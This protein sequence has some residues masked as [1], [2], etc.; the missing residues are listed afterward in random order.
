MKTLSI[1]HNNGNSTKY[2]LIEDGNN[3]PIAY[4]IETSK[5]VIEVLENARKGRIRIKLALGD[6]KTGKDWGEVHDISGRIGLSKGSDARYP[7][8][9]YN[10]RSYGGG[11]ILDHCIVKVQVANG[12]KV[13]YQA[14]NYTP[15]VISITI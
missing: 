3:L 14:K 12:G 11:A 2:Q 9:V 8:L 15:P 10:S 1:D 5:E 7:I 13:L 6:T 4:H